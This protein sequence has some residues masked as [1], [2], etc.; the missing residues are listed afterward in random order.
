MPCPFLKEGRGRYCHAAPVRKLILD[1]PGVTGGGRCTSPDYRLCEFVGKDDTGRDRCPHLEEVHLQY[2]AASPVVKLVPFSETQRSPCTSTGY[3]YC[4]SY[5]LLARP[6]QTTVP[7]PDLLYAPNHLWLEVEELGRCHAGIDAFLA[8]TVGSVDQVTFVTTHGTHR[9]TVA[10]TVNGVEWPMVFPNPL[11]IERV[12]SHLRGD[13]ARLTTD[14]Y[15]A[16]WLFEG[17]E[18]P[19]RT[20]VGLVGGGQAA[21]WLAEEREHLAYKIQE[22]QGLAC[23]GGYARR[24]V[25]R[26]LPRQDVVAL[27]ERFFSRRDWALEE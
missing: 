24:G 12:N 2:C 21:A 4:D 14:P 22:V 13:P 26:M 3:R 9:P 11:I 20:R 16:G 8:D 5:L 19:G 6:N 27:F 17:W 10:L 23:D 7:P 18:L 25:G 1:G 15:G